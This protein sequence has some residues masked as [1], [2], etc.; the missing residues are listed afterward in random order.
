MLI[1]SFR[2]E[3]DDMNSG[4][5]S[6]IFDDLSD[7]ESGDD[8]PLNRTGQ[9]QFMF[10]RPCLP[11]DHVIQWTTDVESD[12]SEDESQET[13]EEYLAQM[14]D[15]PYS[16]E[17]HTSQLKSGEILVGGM[18][19]RGGRKKG[20]QRRNNEGK[21]K[22]RPNPGGHTVTKTPGIVFPSEMRVRLPYTANGI[23]TNAGATNIG[24]RWHTNAV[25]DVDPIFGSTA[26]VG[27][28]E[29]SQLYHFYR[30]MG[31]K[32]W[33]ELVNNE[34]F[35]VIVYTIHSNNDLGTTGALAAAQSGNPMCQT[36]MLAPNGYGG[37]TRVISS[38]TISAVVGSTAPLY[39]DNYRA[40]INGIPADL[41][42]FGIYATAGPVNVFTVNK[43][44]SY[45]IRVSMDTK[46]YGRTVLTQ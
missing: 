5:N 3:L 26:T 46:F 42:W 36:T 31:V 8:T 34:S 35:P 43:G 9:D 14:G 16:S 37:A 13:G 30:C 33:V 40:L 18:P 27:F 45:A 29:I 28:Y 2:S 21:R 19:Q 32:V 25:Y 15:L 12:D 6:H 22:P 1:R 20:K 17:N 24:Q 11:T 7:D 4:G 41:T 38:H 39:E 23:I 44:I 10:Q